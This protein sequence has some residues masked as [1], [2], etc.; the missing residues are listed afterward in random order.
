M[1]IRGSK[2]NAKTAKLPEIWRNT[3]KLN[4]FGLD[5]A[6]PSAVWL[7]TALPAVHGMLPKSDMFTLVVIRLFRPVKNGLHI[8]GFDREL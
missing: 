7:Y 1:L 2:G 4:E 3:L 5:T 8:P 6:L